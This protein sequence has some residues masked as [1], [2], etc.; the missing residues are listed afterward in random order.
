[1]QTR[2]KA[3]TTRWPPRHRSL[4][5]NLT[6]LVFVSTCAVAPLS[7]DT[8]PTVN[9][10]KPTTQLDPDVMQKWSRSCALCHVDGTGGAPRVGRTDEW[11]PRLAEGR[12]VL[13]ERT[14]EG[15]NNMPPLGYCMSC[16]ADDFRALIDF[17]AGAEQ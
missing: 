16:E 14:V 11:Q 7:A 15:F 2:S 5:T 3:H 6:V 17:M 12:D 13:F 1:L 8:A 10:G 9:A 4:L